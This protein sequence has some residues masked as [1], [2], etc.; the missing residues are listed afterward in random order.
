MRDREINL[1]RE[2][3]HAIN[4]ELNLDTLLQLIANHA[5]DLLQAKTVLIPLLDEDF[6]QYTYRA[7][8]GAD[9]REIVGESLPIDYGVCGWVWKN[10]R[11]WWRGM[12]NE[13]PEEERIRWEEEAGTL[14]LVPLVG[15]THFLGGI[16]GLHKIGDN[17]FS[18]RDLVLLE[19]FAAQAAIAI[20]NA[21]AFEALESS[22]EHSDQLQG[23]LR[24]VN[25]EL[26]RA[27][28]QLEFM[29]L[30]DQL[31]QLPNTSL[32][33]DRL[34]Q[35]ILHARRDKL[36]L[37]LLL[38]DLDNFKE[39]NDAYGHETGDELLKQVAARITDEE[40]TPETIARLGGDEFA[41][42]LTE[43]D[44]QQAAGIAQNLLTAL[45]P[46]FKTGNHNLTISASIGISSFPHHGDDVSILLS[47]ADIAMYSAKRTKTRIAIYNESLGQI[48]DGSMALIG[49][50]RKALDHW[51]FELYYQPQIDL[52]TRRIMGVEA[53]SRWN[54]PE[55]G[56][57]RPDI[58][59]AMLEQIGLMHQFTNLVMETAFEQC[60]RWQ[61]AGHKLR[62]SVNVTVQ[63]LLEPG[64]VDR[65]R[66]LMAR[67]QVDDLVV[68]ELT[69]NIFLSD[70]EHIDDVMRELRDMGLKMSIDDFGTGHSS[71]N[72]LK[73]LPVSEIK[74]DRSFV[75]Q[76]D[77][78]ADDVVIVQ[79][80]I[81]LARNLDLLVVAEGVE[82][83]KVLHMLARLGCDIAQG[84]YMARPM[85]AA[86]LDAFI[87]ENS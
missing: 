59:I 30:Y 46:E 80:T 72:R 54:H 7:G 70:Y 47:R 44:E 5:R 68:L 23:E 37:S 6:S 60:A 78:D 33:K 61:Q 45:E 64:F 34:K 73:R 74:I 31:T 58:F 63:D 62:M 36:P 14:I 2:T 9:I 49:D 75:S 4:G 85:P 32:F 79:S 55:Q 82:N 25:R 26:K 10:K 53:L 20:E 3:A 35:A 57:I 38:F 22:R 11:A 29:A 71:L 43:T 27:N 84:F 48:L 69:E 1:L 28:Q 12:L 51:E 17:D 81:D 8:S 77:S 52:V 65:T 40:K 87:K 76:M 39:I 66:A 56:F 13:L 67:H 42:I 15:K 86:E 24:K 19:V 21:M 50:L 41:L 16:A 18:Q 83:E